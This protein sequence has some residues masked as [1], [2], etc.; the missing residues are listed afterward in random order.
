MAETAASAMNETARSSSGE[1]RGAGALIKAAR[2]RQG[3]HIA[4]L[5]A[6]IKVAPRKIEALEA[7]R[8]D[9][10]PGPTFTRALAQAVCRALKTDPAPVME[11]LPAADTSMLDSSFGDLN[12]PFAGRGGRDSA[13]LARLLAVL[14]GPWV[15]ASFVL[16]LA[17][18]A[19]W[20]LPAGSLSRLAG[21]G[22]SGA[23]GGGSASSSQVATAPTGVG[24]T[25]SAAAQP[26]ADSGAAI[27][28]PAFPA[29]PSSAA[30][31]TPMAAAGD[32]AATTASQPLQT[33]AAPPGAA[34]ELKGDLRIQCSGRTWVEIVNARGWVLVSRNLEAGESIALDGLPP[35]QVAIGNV[36]A[37]QMTY[38][39]QPV[40][41][42]SRA[43]D[44]VARVELR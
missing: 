21:G 33:A 19:V 5:A 36:T 6:A 7:D 25:P 35:L 38:K 30:V 44:N 2:E 12:E 18:A 27:A 3:M 17:A 39:G 41:L 43:R 37:T 31:G 1:T 14:S 29:S 10:L 13:P 34:A 28:V 15:I 40:D 26:A 23:A 11:L 16:V 22:A 20:W 42:A 32:T 24:A 8:W 4:T 9:E